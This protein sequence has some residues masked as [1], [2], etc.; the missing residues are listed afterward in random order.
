[1]WDEDRRLSSNKTVY[2]GMVALVHAL[3]VHLVVV[4]AC[5]VAVLCRLPRPRLGA[6]GVCVGVCLAAARRGCGPG[7]GFLLLSRLF[8]GV[9][10]NRAHAVMSPALTCA[11]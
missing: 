10:L 9:S 8:F 1:M 7:P 6:S 5:L 3:G 2:S 4:A 11:F